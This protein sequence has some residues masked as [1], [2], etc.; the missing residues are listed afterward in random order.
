MIL[1]ALCLI[2]GVLGAV[3]QG[4]FNFNQVLFAPIDSAANGNADESAIPIY[5]ALITFF[6]CMIIFQNIIPIAIYISVDIAKSFQV[7]SYIKPLIFF[8]F[9]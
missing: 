1:F 8:N 6:Y 5:I 7:C 2:C 4:A 9:F 3:Y